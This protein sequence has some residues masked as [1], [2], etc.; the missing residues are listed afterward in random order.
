MVFQSVPETAEVVMRMVCNNAPVTNT[1]YARKTGGY[2]LTSL[3]TLVVAVYTN[4][5]TSI[6]PYLPI[7][8]LCDGATGRGLQ[9]IN[10]VEYVHSPGVVAGAAATNPT[11]SNVALAFKR[12]SGLTGR[13]A[14]GRVYIGPLP[15]GALTTDEN[16]VSSAVAANLL[17]GLDEMRI[18]IAAQ[19]WIEV[20]VSRY[21]GG[22]KR[23]TGV[24]FPVV[25]YSYSNLRVDSRRDRLP[26]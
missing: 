16:Y 10:D 8:L 14:R 4:F 26:Q 20:I 13:S 25:D 22:T 11:P 6:L 24:T 18:E 2:D 7:A 15:T 23:P 21:T 1:F 3:T 19:G 17:G 9:F 12:T 5:I